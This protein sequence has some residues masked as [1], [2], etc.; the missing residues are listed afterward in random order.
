MNETAVI[1]VLAAYRLT[2]LVTK[3]SITAPARGALVEYAYA[4]SRT[5]PNRP[6]AAAVRSWSL[7][8]WAEYAL[9]DK[10]AP[11]L[12]ELVTCPWCTGIYVAFGVVFARRFFP[13]A[14]SPVARA[15]AVAAAA[16]FIE[17]KIEPNL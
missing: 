5:A 12:A 11:R 9:D 14:W 16:A 15:L 3:D 17:S 7:R 2:R 4:T 8:T 6:D 13:R 1:D 10:H